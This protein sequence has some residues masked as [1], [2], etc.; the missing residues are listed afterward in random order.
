MQYLDDGNYLVEY[1]DKLSSILVDIQNTYLYH[2]AYNN[3]HYIYTLGVEHIQI[4]QIDFIRYLIYI[5]KDN[6][7]IIYSNVYLTSAISS[8]RMY[9]ITE[10]TNEY[11]RIDC[12]GGIRIIAATVSII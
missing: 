1:Y 10:R 2:D 8:Y 7:S 9:L 5:T 12:S 4:V 3:N 6:H 11:H